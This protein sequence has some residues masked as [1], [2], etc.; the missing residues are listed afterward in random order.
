MTPRRRKEIPRRSP[1]SRQSSRRAPVPATRPARLGPVQYATRAVCVRLPPACQSLSRRESAAD[2][3]PMK[4]STVSSIRRARA[5]RGSRLREGA[6]CGGAGGRSTSTGRW[7][8]RGPCGWPRPPSQST[9]CWTPID[10][11]GG[12]AVGVREGA[13]PL[14]GQGESRAPWQQQLTRM[15]PGSRR[16]PLLKA[17]P[18]L[19]SH[20]NGGSATLPPFAVRF[21]H[22]A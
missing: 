18:R 9:L 19:L 2:R 15:P 21:R 3:G 10:L 17:I 1:W 4:P 20:G 14:P 7:R 8:R 22:A 5:R 16:V 6:G 11:Q 12:A 13:H